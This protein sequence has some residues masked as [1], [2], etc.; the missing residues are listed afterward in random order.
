MAQ[1]KAQLAQRMLA[2]ELT[3]HLAQERLEGTGNQRDGHRA[4][5]VHTTSG[6]LALQI[7][8]DRLSAFDPVLI[9]KHQ[10]RIEGFDD[11]VIDMYARGMSVRE[12]RA[13]LLQIYG[14]T[15]R[16]TVVCPQVLAG[17][18]GTKSL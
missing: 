1:L 15:A 13:H 16:V 7:P 4:K 3:H 18:S 5:T 14:G 9:G 2:A 8:R 10:R 17:Q 12:T 11:H 6:D